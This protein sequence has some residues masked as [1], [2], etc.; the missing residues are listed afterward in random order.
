MALANTRLKLVNH[1]TADAG[2]QCGY[3][4]LDLVQPTPALPDPG[5]RNLA[6]PTWPQ[7][8]QQFL[9]STTVQQKFSQQWE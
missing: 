2:N 5:P 6:D 9:E 7:R 1:G 4:L 3:P 8:Y